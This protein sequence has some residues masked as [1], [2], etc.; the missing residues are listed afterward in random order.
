LDGGSNTTIVFTGSVGT[1]VMVPTDVI[2][3]VVVF[4]DQVP[5]EYGGRTGAVANV[6]T[7]QGTNQFHGGF[8]AYYTNKSLIDADAVAVTNHL[9][10]QGYRRYAPG[11]TLGGPIAQ[12][13]V[14][15]FGA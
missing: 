15:F 14:F 10:K 9:P 7:R 12:N 2:Q 4:S 13:K 5:A 1:R 11:F 3:E 8:H 6:I